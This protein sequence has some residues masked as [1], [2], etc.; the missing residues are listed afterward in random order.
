LRRRRRC[1]AGI[2]VAII[3][4]VGASGAVPAAALGA[5]RRLPLLLLSP[6]RSAPPHSA[7]PSPV[8]AAA[9]LSTGGRAAA[10]N[11]AAWAALDLTEELT[12]FKAVHKKG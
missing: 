8:A 6:F 7:D 3:L 9:D 2:A 10:V 12:S 5:E 1:F 11:A 4:G